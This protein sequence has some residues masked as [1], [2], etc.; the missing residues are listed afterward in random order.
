MAER[1]RWTPTS[2]ERDAAALPHGYA[3]SMSNEAKPPSV[4]DRLSAEAA[5]LAAEKAVNRAVS[6]VEGMAHGVLDDVERLVFGSVGGAQAVIDAE[7]QGGDALERARAA[8]GLQP[9]AP[10][11][12]PKEDPLERARAQLAE[13]KARRAPPPDEPERKKTL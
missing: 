8:H 3:S 2:P 1:E 5:K 10:P 12:A 13:M 6:A 9:T 11:A 4:A 7:S